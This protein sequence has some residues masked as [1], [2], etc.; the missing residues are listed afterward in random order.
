MMT[1]NH[2]AAAAVVAGALLAPGAGADIIEFDFPIDVAQAVP[3]PVIPAGFDPS[4]SAVVTFDTDTKEL[5]WDIEYQ[6]LSG[7]IVSPGAHFHGPADFGE[8]AGIQVFIVGGAG[9]P[10]PQPP[11]GRLM[12]S[13]TL[14]S[15]QESDLLAGLWYVNIHTALNPA[16][17]IRGQVIPAPATLAILGV[18]GLAAR[19]RRRQVQARRSTGG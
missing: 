17:E 4:G 9:M 1:L 5:V 14:T 19:R 11:S 16:G 6:G 15:A 8:T 13:A 18:A 3:A 10:I 7:D 12:G 2:R